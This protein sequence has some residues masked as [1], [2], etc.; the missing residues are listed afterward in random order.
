VAD[1]DYEGF[2]FEQARHADDDRDRTA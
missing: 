2:V 1:K